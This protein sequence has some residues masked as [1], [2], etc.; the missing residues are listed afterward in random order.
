MPQTTQVLSL[1]ENS[2]YLSP[3]KATK[4]VQDDSI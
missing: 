4:T 2:D 3:E 1:N